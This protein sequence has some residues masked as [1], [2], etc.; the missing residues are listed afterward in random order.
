VVLA[1]TLRSAALR[2]RP[3]PLRVVEAVWSQKS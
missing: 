3:D 1:A 2:A